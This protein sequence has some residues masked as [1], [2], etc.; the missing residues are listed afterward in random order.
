MDRIELAD[1]AEQILDAHRANL[2][3][4]TFVQIKIEITEGDFTSVC[5]PDVSPM[6]WKIQLNP[7]RHTDFFEI[8]YSIVESLFTILFDDLRIANSKEDLKEIQKRIV[9]RLTTAFCEIFL[10]E[11]AEEDL[12]EED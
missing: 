11:E 4:D 7:E 2:L 3:L 8:Q 6:S 9:A 12:D 10:D 1:L 5:I